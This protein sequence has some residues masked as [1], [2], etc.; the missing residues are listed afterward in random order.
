MD[1]DVET[2]LNY[3]LDTETTSEIAFNENIHKNNEL[4]DLRYLKD[5]ELSINR[6]LQQVHHNVIVSTLN[7][8][9]GDHKS[10]SD[11]FEDDL[12]ASS[13]DDDEENQDKKTFRKRQVSASLY[14]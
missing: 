1:N 4:F 7:K 5:W 6:K 12:L 10:E 11:G 14:K 13:S 2:F 3:L 8:V 9:D